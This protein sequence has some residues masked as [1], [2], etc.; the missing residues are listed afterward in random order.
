MP[1]KGSGASELTVVD[2]FDGGVGWIAYPDETMQRASHA[3]ESDGGLWLVDPVDVEGLDDLLEEYAD[4]EGVAVLLDRHKRDA[5]TIANR[6]DVPVYVPE[7]MDGV[8]G[9]IDA[10]IKRFDRRLADFDVIRLIDNPLWQEAA[11]VDGET[12]VVPESLGTAEYFRA[13]DEPLGVHPMLRILPPRTLRSY[14]PD[15][16]LVGHGEGIF[17][18]VGRTIRRAIDGSRRTALPLYLRSVRELFSN[19]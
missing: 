2:R 4:P 3:I 1:M 9:D 18:D 11:L 6:H 13:P 7:W 5:A 19:R 16:L 10:P 15:R 17:E 8:V 14:D 12:L